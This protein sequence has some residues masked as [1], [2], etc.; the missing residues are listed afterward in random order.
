MDHMRISGI[1]PSSVILSQTK[2]IPNK[3]KQRK[4]SQTK[5]MI[6]IKMSHKY[7]VY[8]NWYLNKESPISDQFII[9]K[10]MNN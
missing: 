7:N 8:F 5:K 2:L 9:L 1:E 4:Q 6:P 10:G 3:A